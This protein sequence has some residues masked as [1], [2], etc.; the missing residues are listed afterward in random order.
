M[1]LISIVLIV[2]VIAVFTLCSVFCIDATALMHL[3]SATTV[4]EARPWIEPVRNLRALAI[5]AVITIQISGFYLVLRSVPLQQAWPRV[6]MVVLPA[7]MI[8]FGNMTA[9]RM[10]AIRKA[11]KGQGSEGAQMLQMLRAPFLKVSLALRISA[12]LGV[13]LLVSVKP[14][15]WGSITLVGTC[16]GIGLLFALLPWP[17]ATA[18]ASDGAV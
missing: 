15:W 13:F 3:R 8:P 10:R 11:F 7:F 5:S 2:H 14:G 9:R 17:R 6:A 1:S 4:S 12:F 16:L 18:A